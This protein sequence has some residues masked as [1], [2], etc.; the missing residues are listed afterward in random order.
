MD[1]CFASKFENRLDE[2][3]DDPDELTDYIVQ[4]MPFLNRYSEGIPIVTEK[5]GP[6]DIQINKGIQ[7]KDIYDDYLIN[8][9]HS[10]N[11]KFD[12]IK[13]NKIECKGCGSSN[14]F[15]DN[16]QSSEICMDCG[17]MDF[18][19]GMEM[20]YKEEQENTEKIINYSYKRENHFN[21]WLSQ[22]QA[23]EVTSIPPEVIEQL[24]S[25]FKK[26]KIKNV[27]EITHTKVR[28][29]LKK[30]KLNKYYEH[31]PYISNILNGIQPKRM[32]QAL[33]EKLRQMFKEIQTPFDKNCPAERKNFLSYSYVL[34]KFC[35]LL[36]EDDYLECF[37]LLKSKEKLYQQDVI[38][39]KICKD[40]QWEFI[41]TT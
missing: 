7:K 14:V 17:C 16:C 13:E 25:E 41:A 29:L 9:E 12:K 15:H 24:R 4:C 18:I 37:P 2:L 6:F 30:L 38:W 11:Y 35:E 39:K 33:E 3:M 32:P 31:V 1:G 10:K 26:I 22:F 8:V 36:S 40:L 34:Y 28:T 19:L 27:N 21:E 20:T 5:K 23:Q